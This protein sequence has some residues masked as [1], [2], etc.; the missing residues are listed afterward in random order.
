MSMNRQSA[1]AWSRLRLFT[2]ALPL[3]MAPLISLLVPALA[4]A[5]SITIAWDPNTD[6]VTAGYYVYYGTQSGN[7]SGY[8]DVSTA[9]TAIINTQDST[10]T[11]Y[12][13]VQAYSSTGD[14]SLYSPEVVWQPSTPTAQPPVLTN[15]GSISTVVGSASV[16]VRLVATD[17]GGLA[18][19]YKASGLPPGLSVAS[20]TGMISGIPTTAGTYKVTATVTNTANLSASQ[21]FTWSVLN[22]PTSNS[23]SQSPS[24]V[25]PGNLTNVVGQSASVQLVA[26][27]PGGLALQYAANGLPPGLSIASSTGRISGKPTAVGTYSVTARVTNTLALSASQSF[28]WTILASSSPGNGGGNGNGSGNNNGGGSNGGGNG[29]G[30]GGNT[31]TSPV[32]SGVDPLAPGDSGAITPDLTPPTLIITGPTIITDPTSGSTYSTTEPNIVL[33]GTA[34]D[35]VGVVSVTWSNDRGGDGVAEGTSSWTTPAI[36]LKMGTNVLTVTAS[37]AAGNVQTITLTVTRS[38]DLHNHLN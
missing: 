14:R 25:N 27:D 20:S 23:T 1:N 17:P 4:E 5:T 6:S 28:T 33:T 24:L 7:Y 35:D 32:Y 15:P 11:Y 26:T 31:G 30:G 18:L 21:S 12:F 22:Q 38:A 19:T 16:S 10:T 9:T 2:I 3:L 13:A 36:D 8:V 34:F 29:N 37:D